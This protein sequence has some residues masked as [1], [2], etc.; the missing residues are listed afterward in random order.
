MGIHAP[1]AFI[2]HIITS[3]ITPDPSIIMVATHVIGYIPMEHTFITVNETSASF[4][5]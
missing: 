5:S 2:I 4:L 3:F 1:S